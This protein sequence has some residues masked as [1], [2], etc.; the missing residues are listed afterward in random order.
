MYTRYF[1]LAEN[2]FALSPDPRYLY[3]SRRHE[4]A[5]AHLSY[6]IEHG[7][8][9]V[10]LTGEVGTGKTLMIRA[11]LERL[12][13]N[14]DVA[15][16]LYPFLSVREFV[17]AICADL[18]IEPAD[19]NSLKALIDSL[20]AYLLANHARGRRTVL[21][22]DEAQKLSH[23]VLE[24]VRLLTNLETTKEKLLQILLIG[25]P[26][27]KGLLAQHGLRQLAQRITARYDLQPLS[28]PETRDYI[29][30]RTR[31]AG[32]PR[33]LFSSAALRWIHRAARGT[34]RL[35]NV[36]CDRAL[37]G[38]YA[39][40]RTH[41][42]LSVARRAARETGQPQP[43]RARFA[44]VAAAAVVAATL[45]FAGSA[46]APGWLEQVAGRDRSPAASAAE[47]V[48]EARVATVAVKPSTARPVPRPAPTPKLPALL[49]AA[50]PSADT[51]AYAALFARWTL[52]YDQLKGPTACA[53]AAQAGL[54]CLLVTGNWTQLRRYDRPAV[55]ELIDTQGE[56]HQVLLTGLTRDRASLAFGGHTY[57]LPLAGIDPYWLGK[58][59]LLWQPP[60]IDQ[61]VLQ[62]GMRGSSIVW[63]R[64]TLARADGQPPGGSDMF[65]ATL[66]R[67]V[68]AFQR[69]HHLPVDGV[70]GEATFLQL[71]LDGPHLQPLGHEG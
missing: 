40:D 12:P 33:P 24:Q 30:H 1:G 61:S 38:A 65:D 63:L 41:V 46:F 8:G 28:P 60:P 67:R 3:M 54:R 55:L 11:L 5:L 66:E 22:V 29:N 6:G 10:Q 31:V 45:G 20:N 7:G 69:L 47:P 13:P 58:A 14:V 34:P 17:G 26:E 39:A 50:S 44:W 53:R 42:S 18:R 56:R 27:L 49:A 43:T 62:P 48:V 52:N 64:E 36:L 68:E 71:D 25:Q 15:L 70:V 16:V 4:E 21:I 9:F 32:A 37:L 59:L 35:I 57:N 23:E 2:P 51:Q 19:P